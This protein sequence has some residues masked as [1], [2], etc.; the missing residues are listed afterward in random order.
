MVKT[1]IIEDDCDTRRLLRHILESEGHDVT[2][3]ENGLAAECCL[4]CA[5]PDLVLTDLNMPERDGIEI[6]LQMRKLDNPPRCLVVSGATDELLQA[7][8]ELGADGYIRKPFRVSDLKE[9]I[10]ALLDGKAC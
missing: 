2:E 1:L 4:N 5:T 6:L 9:R 3:A 10:H 8:V 7:S